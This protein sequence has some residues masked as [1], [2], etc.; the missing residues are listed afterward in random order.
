MRTFSVGDGRVQTL[1]YTLDSRSLIV[2]LRGEAQS[3][4]WIKINVRP[5]TE[6]AWWDIL[7]ATARRRFR[8][9]DSLYGPGGALSSLESEEARRD[10]DPNG[11]A[12]DVSFCLAPLRVATAWDWTDK[13]D[14][15]CVFDADQNQTI[16]LRTPHKTHIRL[17]RLSPD[18]SKLLAATVDDMDGSALFEVWD[19]SRNPFKV[20]PEHA[21]AELSG[22]NQMMCERHAAIQRGCA[23][24]FGGLADLAFDGRFVAAVDASKPVL[25]VWDSST[26]MLGEEPPMVPAHELNWN[27]SPHKG[28]KV[29]VGFAPRCLAFSPAASL[30]AVGGDRLILFDPLTSRRRQKRR[31]GSAVSAMAFSSDGQELVCG[32]VSGSV[33]LWNNR[34]GRRVRTLEWDCGPISA[35]AFAPDG[36]TCA[37]GTETGQIIVWDRD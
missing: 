2:D 8:L 7:S 17:I 27:V 18:G 24:P 21:E 20:A 29:N 16:D 14:G 5:A 11:S 35:V 23:N 19:L 33:E 37:A 3:H 22:W 4:P 34:S 9:R 25:L 26:S 6:L 32:T 12:F 30:L 13:G 31:A 36:F 1:A 10:W 15:V 28:R